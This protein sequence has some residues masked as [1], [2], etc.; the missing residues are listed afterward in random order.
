M[1]KQMLMHCLERK[2]KRVVNNRS[3]E[4]VMMMMKK[5]NE[6]TNSSGRELAIDLSIMVGGQIKKQTCLDFEKKEMER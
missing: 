3:Q 2:K 1:Y 6:S 5:T 4:M